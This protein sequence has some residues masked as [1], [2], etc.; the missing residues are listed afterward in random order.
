MD[1]EQIMKKNELDNPIKVEVVQ[2]IKITLKKGSGTTKDF[3]RFV[4]YYYD[5]N[6]ERVFMNDSQWEDV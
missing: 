6:G 5:F 3:V 2:L 4:D 1:Q